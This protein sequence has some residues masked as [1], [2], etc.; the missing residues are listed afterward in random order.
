MMQLSIEGIL[1]NYTL[2]A[3][4]EPELR[5]QANYYLLSVIDHQDIWKVTEVAMK[6]YSK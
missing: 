6:Q 5:E 2:L 3:S 4:S 1:N